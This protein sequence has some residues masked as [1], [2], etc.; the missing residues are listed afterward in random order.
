LK[1]RDKFRVIAL[2]LAIAILLGGIPIVSG[3]PQSLH[4]AF[5]I[6][7]C[8]PIQAVNRVS[9][10]CSL[11][12]FADSSIAQTLE[13]RGKVSAAAPLVII[14][15]TEAPDPPPPKILV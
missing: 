9:A 7:V 5:G 11:P 13:E 8:Q 10:T 14:S 2:L 3:A 4:P 15:A 12:V 1:A 6:D